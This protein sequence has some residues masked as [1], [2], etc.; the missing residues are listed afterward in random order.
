MDLSELVERCGPRA[1]ASHW[2]AARVWGLELVADGPD[3]LTVPRSRGRLVVPG[4]NVHRRDLGPDDVIVVD[5]VPLT[6]PPRTVLDLCRALPLQEGVV[7]ADSALRK[8]D[9]SEDELRGVLS[10]AWGHHASRPRAV[11]P[12]VD[13]RSESVL[14]SLAGVLL[15]TSELP[16][17]ERQWEIRDQDGRFVARAD[18]CWPGHRL[19]VEVDG[20]AFHSD[21]AAYRHDRERINS[22]ERL[23]WRVLRFS[24]ED[25]RSKPADVLA[26]I[27]DCLRLV[28]A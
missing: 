20:F 5:E 2:T 14:E 18:F 9:V 25:V 17:A 13:A 15:M 19:V 12:L 3:S 22:L 26:V 4:W 16:P 24:W 27:R 10:R 23:G 6:T 8:C 28:A 21:R 1:T 11:A 7:V